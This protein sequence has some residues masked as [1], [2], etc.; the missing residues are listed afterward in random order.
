LSLLDEHVTLLAPDAFATAALLVCSRAGDVVYAR[1][2]HPPPLLV[3]GTD[4]RVLD[5]GARPPLGAGGAPA[6]EGHL[7]LPPGATLVLYT[8]GLVEQR[9]VDLDDGIAMMIDAIDGLGDASADT[10]SKAV[11]E[12]CPGGRN[13]RDDVCLLV[14]R[15]VDKVRGHDS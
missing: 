1:A 3:A 12:A 4:V 5:D 10:W 9:G 6:E 7:T 8:D 11:L 2:G 14:V 13:P 15:R